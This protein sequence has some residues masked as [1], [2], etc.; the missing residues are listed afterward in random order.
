MDVLRALS[1]GFILRPLIFG[2]SQ[3]KTREGA[4]DS[5]LSKVV[6]ALFWVGGCWMGKVV[7]GS[8]SSAVCP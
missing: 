2:S 5:G 1:F 3:T 6:G 7:T 4:I 8:R